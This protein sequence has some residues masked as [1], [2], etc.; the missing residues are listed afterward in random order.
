VTL[1]QKIQADLGLH[2]IF[3]GH[4]TVAEH[5]Q[6]DLLIANQATES[7]GSEKLASISSVEEAMDLYNNA[8]IVIGT[9]LHSVLLSLAAGTP[10]V[11]L[12]YQPKAVGCLQDIGWNFVAD[13]QEFTVDE[14]KALVG[15]AL[16]HDT[17]V[18]TTAR[19]SAN[20]IR[21]FYSSRLS[22]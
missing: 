3:T 7:F 4:S 16:Q 10:A 6:D 1:A 21:E 22:Q 13:V 14:V 2:P 12:A 8:T 20:Q 9:R 17:S 18:I 15:V 11:C 5:D 19:T